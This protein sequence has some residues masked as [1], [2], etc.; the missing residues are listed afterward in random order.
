VIKLGHNHFRVLTIT[1]DVEMQNNPQPG[2]G[3]NPQRGNSGDRILDECTAI[4]QLISDLESRHQSF[5]SLTT[6]IL[7]DRAQLSELEAASSDIIRAYRNATDRM[8]KIKSNPESGSPRNAPQVGR[9]D[10]RLKASFQEF[11]VI[12]ADFRAKMKEQQTRQYRIV[13]PDATDEEVRQVVD[14]PSAQVF[15][16]ALMNA[17]RRGQSQSALN[18]VRQR[19]A[20]IQNIEQTMIE[21]GQL[22]QDMDNLVMQQDVQVKQIEEK[23]IEVQENIVK[24]NQELDHG[25][26][27]ARAARK[28][29]W[30]LCGIAVVLVCVIIIV[31]LIWWFIIRQQAHV[32]T[33]H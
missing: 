13:N 8:R 25:I 14:D 12:E 28:K 31:V 24:G 11:K 22:F 21:L 2:Y 17:D 23:G 3:G 32:V 5:R 27:S 29:K 7:S 18:A 6:R 26:K 20:A 9:V 15:Q 16:Q 33:G 1:D 10:R 4:D 19:H 30:I